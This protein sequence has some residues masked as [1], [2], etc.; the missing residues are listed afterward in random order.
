MGTTKQLQKS[1]TAGTLT[2]TKITQAQSIEVMQTLLH[3]GISTLSW[4][5]NF[6][7][8]YAFDEVT[9]EAG[10][11]PS[12]GEYAYGDRAD[13]EQ[14]AGVG[15]GK[16]SHQEGLRMCLLRR[17]RSSRVDRL[18]D[19][20]ET[21][22]F[23]ALA[24]GR[25]RALQILV[26]SDP[27]DRAKVL[28]T[29]TFTIKYDAESEGDRVAAGIEMG[30]SGDE[31]VTVEET[32][33]KFRILQK[34]VMQMCE[35][36]PDLPEEKHLG[37]NM[38]HFDEQHDVAPGWKTAET[39]KLL[40]PSVQG[41]EKRPVQ[42]EQLK[43][44]SHSASLRISLVQPQY[45]TKLLQSEA[46]ALP[47]TSE[48]HGD[49][50]IYDEL[51]KSM[52]EVAPATPSTVIDPDTT[53]KSYM[54]QLQDKQTA[55]PAP[56]SDVLHKAS[57]G[58]KATTPSDDREDTG[59]GDG[60]PSGAFGESLDTQSSDLP[61]MRSVL[62]GAVQPEHLT[63]GDTQTQASMRPPPVPVYSVPKVPSIA[64][65]AATSTP[66]QKLQL[67]PA[68]VS[69]LH[70]NQT[71][72]TESALKLAKAKISH[73]KIGD[74]LYCQCGKQIDCTCC[75]TS[76]HYHCQGFSGA[77]DP[78]IPENYT[79]YHCLLHGRDDSTRKVIDDLVL[80]RRAMV[81]ALQHGLKTKT[82]LGKRL[83]VRTE[84]AGNVHTHLREQGF[85]VPVAS[86]HS[87][88][89]GKSGKPH[90]VPINGGTNFDRMIRELFDPQL[91][92]EQMYTKSAVIPTQVKEQLQ[93]LQL[94]D[95]PV[96][97]MSHPRQKSSATPTT[98]TATASDLDPRSPATPFRTPSH[99]PGKRLK[100]G[101]EGEDLIHDSAQE[102]GTKRLRTV[103]TTW[104][105]LA[106]G[107][108]SP[109]PPRK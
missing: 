32:N 81:T 14:A 71:N 73:G 48:F 101:R 98:A 34:A 36:L 96:A 49:G 77:E 62:Q 11:I 19:G 53:D 25:L 9:Y 42:F 33:L 85:V 103:Q 94:A 30:G 89:F 8:E 3:S 18:L 21:N 40:F 91:H 83:G 43:S 108:P 5:R 22:V 15:D 31:P 59:F 55:T 1:R 4:Y 50:T 109:V 70:A 84:T 82:D 13:D 88:G 46:P 78:R 102:V 93:R 106:N 52:F 41:W 67:D 38:I 97:T 35:K 76:Q 63:Q 86:S 61:R 10:R 58:E 57:Q 47:E 60:E 2:K 29:Y 56:T 92:V 44:G 66:L 23:P 104:T 6:F 75:G 90:F 95:M 54:K 37:L 65:P 17:K 79:C 7:S 26:H 107:L 87:R 80:K 27:S 99:P 45:T 12:Y 39:D 16:K 51:D 100:R 72:L 69:K 20:L 28:E 105:I 74:I 24:E 64:P 68:V